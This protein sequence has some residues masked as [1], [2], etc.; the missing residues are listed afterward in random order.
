MTWIIC[1]R[2]CPY[3]G[4]QWK[5]NKAATDQVNYCTV[6]YDP[7][8]SV[9][10]ESSK[11]PKRKI[12]FRRNIVLN[13]QYSPNE[14]FV[15]SLSWLSWINWHNVKNEWR[16]MWSQ[17]ALIFWASLMGKKIQNIEDRWKAEKQATTPLRERSLQLH[18]PSFIAFSHVSLTSYLLFFLLAFWIFLGGRN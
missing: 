2:T 18:F 17:N 15:E 4:F 16:Y 12:G 7:C 13:L 9:Y 14:R 3:N 8:V 10:R 11:N 1:W 6:F 5:W